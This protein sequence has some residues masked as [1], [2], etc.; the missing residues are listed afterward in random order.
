MAINTR[1]QTDIAFKKLAGKTFGNPGSTAFQESIDTNVQLGSATLF[2]E[3]IPSTGLTEVLY[4]TS[5]GAGLGV[6]Q[7]VEM[8]L[9]PLP[10]GNYNASDFDGGSDSLDD[11]DSGNSIVDHVFVASFTGDYQSQDGGN[12]DGANQNPKAGTLFFKNNFALTGSNGGVQFVPPTFG[13][14]YQVQIFDTNGN[15]L[16]PATDSQD[17]YFDYYSGVLV[18]QDKENTTLAPVKIKGYIY[19]GKFVNESILSAE[20][21]T[22]NLNTVLGAGN[23]A[24]ISVILSGSEDVGGANNPPLFVSGGLVSFEQSANVSASLFT[25]SFIQVEDNI[26]VVGNAFVTGNLGVQ[27]NTVIAGNLTVNGT[28][29]T[30]ATLDLEVTD[31]FIHL[32]SGSTSDTDSGIAVS[33][34]NSPSDNSALYWDAGIQ[35]WAIDNRGANALG[36]SADHDSHLI[37]AIAFSGTPVIDGSG[38]SNISQPT[39][40]TDANGGPVTDAAYGQMFVDISDS[41]DGGLYIYLP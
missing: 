23:S 6:V 19:I 16:N 1:I 41:T 33:Y 10:A 38:T 15:E 24:S 14:G 36:D 12:G 30:V 8:E 34:G 35:S 26:D 18:R 25:A 13:L 29:T 37:T 4:A 22:P 11:V 5:S 39:L 31:K 7:Y 17:F 40:G 9:S 20:T 2:G 3:T 32:A 27:G 21:P 28:T